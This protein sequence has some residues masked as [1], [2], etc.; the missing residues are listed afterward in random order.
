MAAI[1]LT[2]LLYVVLVLQAWWI[3]RRQLASLLGPDGSASK[4]RE[5]FRTRAL[6]RSGAATATLDALRQV[7]RERHV[8]VSLFTASP[9]TPLTRPQL[10]T[11]LW[12]GLTT[13]FTAN[14]AL[15]AV[16]QPDRPDDSATWRPLAPMSILLR[17][18]ISAMLTVPVL[19][20]FRLLFR[21][22][23]GTALDV[24]EVGVSSQAD[25]RLSRY[26][27]PTLAE[28]RLGAV[29]VV[30]KETF[31]AEVTVGVA[32]DLTHSSHH[33]DDDD[34][35]MHTPAGDAVDVDGWDHGGG[36]PPTTPPDDT[37]EANGWDHGST[38]VAT[39]RK[40]P[41]LFSPTGSV[42][43]VPDDQWF[44]P[45][46]P[47]EHPDVTAHEPVSTIVAGGMHTARSP[48]RPMSLSVDV[49]S[50]L[51][52]R[53]RTVRKQQQR[54]DEEWEG[55]ME[56][57][58]TRVGETTVPPAA[59]GELEDNLKVHTE[60]VAFKRQESL[61]LP[62]WTLIVVYTLSSTYMVVCLGYTWWL[63]LRFPDTQSNDTLKDPA[64]AWL[65]ANAISLVVLALVLDP[66]FLIIYTLAYFLPHKRRVALRR[67][68]Q[69]KLPPPTALPRLGSL[70]S[71]GHDQ[72]ASA[73]LF[74]PDILTDS[75]FED[76]GDRDDLDAE[77]HTDMVLRSPDRSPMARNLVWGDEF[78]GVDETIPEIGLSDISHVGL[79]D[80]TRLTSP[81]R[82][83]IDDEAAQ[84]SA[85]LYMP[86]ASA[87]EWRVPPA[88]AHPRELRRGSIED[89]DAH[90][91]AELVL[92][93]TIASPGQIHLDVDEN[94][95]TAVWSDAPEHLVPREIVTFEVPTDN[96][97][98][99][100]LPVYRAAQP[101]P[102]VEW[103]ETVPEQRRLPSVGTAYIPPD[104]ASDD[105]GDRPAR[106][107]ATQ[108]DATAEWAVS[109]EHAVPDPTVFRQ[110]PTAARGTARRMLPSHDP[111][112]MQQARAMFMDEDNNGTPTNEWRFRAPG[113]PNDDTV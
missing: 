57:Q 84:V 73:D 10:V 81:G 97:E 24:D 80:T 58:R 38:P 86:D 63:T 4:A 50:P 83:D 3:D 98:S 33:D 66:I 11:T 96:S 62:H 100:S 9:W 95:N 99:D 107:L 104:D 39:P 111:E 27:V 92:H 49:G 12:V 108:H 91:S 13:A 7:L 28:S 17:A 44:D 32:D 2:S 87:V 90:V 40:G 103:T 69:S 31:T 64:L 23:K 14:A 30:P 53:V 79:N 61:R 112:T 34:Q 35:T 55:T 25:D 60:E 41:L 78:G 94:E 113:N 110:P 82:G 59:V 22:V 20:V 75:V 37:I 16:N 85:D 19:W 29:D 51:G 106:Y 5:V 68:Q 43:F 101:E 18:T 42:G 70:A 52:G 36:L 15:F 72:A 76:T 47:P 71:I 8:I 77:E 93:D 45:A 102:S 56:P 67:I 46:E 89:E 74:V 88:I 109:P 1:G 54:E 105:S 48:R 65:V 21:Q 6:L 26:V